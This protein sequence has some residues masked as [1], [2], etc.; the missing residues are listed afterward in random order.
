MILKCRTPITC[1]DAKTIEGEWCSIK[2]GVP[3]R[4]RTRSKVK[5]YLVRFMMINNH[6]KQ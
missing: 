4:G 5:T 1:V 3:D 6:K 2:F